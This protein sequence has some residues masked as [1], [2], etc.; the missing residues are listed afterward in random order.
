M[1][2]TATKTENAGNCPHLQSIF[3]C[4]SEVRT[5]ILTAL[6]WETL[7]FKRFAVTV[8]LIRYLLN[9]NVSHFKADNI[10]C[11]KL[12]CILILLCLPFERRET[13]VLESFM[14]KEAYYYCYGFNMKILEDAVFTKT[15]NYLRV[16]LL[17][18]H[19]LYTVW[20]RFL[21]FRKYN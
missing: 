6:K 11:I 15:Q 18:L 4:P 3:N 19:Y 9:V 12:L 7:T 20:H 8:R 13:Y 10:Y 2:N 16:L 5:R 21:H 14:T 17:S 1:S